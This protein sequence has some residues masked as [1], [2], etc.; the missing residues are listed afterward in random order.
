MVRSGERVCR[1]RCTC[2]LSQIEASSEGAITV[3]SLILPGSCK[4]CIPLTR[5]LARRCS[6]EFRT[7]RVPRE[8]E[9]HKK[10]R[11][12]RAAGNVPA[13]PL[14]RQSVSVLRRAHF[15]A[16]GADRSAFRES[17]RPR[18]WCAPRRR[19]RRCAQNGVLALPRHVAGVA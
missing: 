15:E 2:H 12:R 7:K 1:F 6:S 13:V 4:V 5:M 3:E 11:T 14:T 18:R 10:N 19:Q 16:D 17:A 9:E 8:Q